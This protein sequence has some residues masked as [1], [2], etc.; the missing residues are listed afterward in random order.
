MKWSWD[1]KLKKREICRIVELT[2]DINSIGDSNF[3]KVADFFITF[4]FTN[5]PVISENT[6]L[7]ETLRDKTKEIIYGNRKTN[8]LSTHK[9]LERGGY[10]S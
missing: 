8:H 7:K 4:K 3:D 1:L 6:E 9:G 5:K 10:Y 2:T